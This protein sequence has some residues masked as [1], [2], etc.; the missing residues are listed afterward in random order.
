MNEDFITKL[1]TAN[2]L[3]GSFDAYQELSKLLI[4]KNFRPI[5]RR[6]L[7]YFK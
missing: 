6:K 3:I 4:Q 2:Y 1:E 5:R 7:N